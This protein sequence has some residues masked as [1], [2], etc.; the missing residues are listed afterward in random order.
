MHRRGP[1]VDK[2]NTDNREARKSDGQA[3]NCIIFVLAIV[4]VRMSRFYEQKQTNHTKC[5]IANETKN[6]QCPYQGLTELKCEASAAV[7]R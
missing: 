6:S 4:A 7:A 3:G 5:T 2:N 1:S